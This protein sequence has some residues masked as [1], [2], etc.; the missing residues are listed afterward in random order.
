MCTKKSSFR[1]M[2][3]IFMC[4]FSV[5]ISNSSISFAQ[6]SKKGVLLKLCEMEKNISRVAMGARRAGLTREEAIDE[7]LESTKNWQDDQK[8]EVL[9]IWM[10]LY[11]I[12]YAQRYTSDPN[13]YANNRYRMCIEKY[14]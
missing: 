8:S 1:A 3:F 9:G 7:M 6:V 10:R 13:E 11:N 4:V 14:L 2:K 12:A 5:I